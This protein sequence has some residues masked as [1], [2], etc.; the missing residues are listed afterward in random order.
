[1]R[2][3]VHERWSITAWLLLSLASPAA[4]GSAS[5]AY[6]VKDINPAPV[7]RS[8]AAPRGFVV[9]D[10]IA[11]FTA[12]DGWHGRELWRS[13]GTFAGTRMVAD[14]NPG[15]GS[16]SPGDL[17]VIG[18][19]L[20]FRAWDGRRGCGLWRSDG[21][22][23]GTEELAVLHAAID[24]CGRDGMPTD[25]TALGPLVLFTASTPETGAELWRS[26][27][28]IAGTSIVADIAAGPD[29]SEPRALTALAGALY[30]IADDSQHGHELWRSDGS[31]AGT[32]LVRDINRGQ[33]SSVPSGRDHARL[34][35][36]NGVLLFAA[37]D[38]A[39]GTELWRSDG[40]ADGTTL[41][42]D[43][44]PG[45]GLDG[46]RLGDTTSPIA[47]FGSGAVLFFSADRREQPP[48]LIVWRSDGTTPGT[49]AIGAIPFGEGWTAPGNL[50]AVGDIAYFSYGTAAA[51]ALWKVDGDG[52]ERLVDLTGAALQTGAFTAAGDRLLFLAPTEGAGCG[53]WRSDG[54][55]AGSA[56]VRDHAA[57][58]GQCPFDAATSA[59]G[60]YL[61][62]RGAEALLAATDTVRGTELFAS[63]GTTAGTH[64]VR[65]INDA[66]AR[67]Q[68]TFIDLADAIALDDALLFNATVDPSVTRLWRSDGTTDGTEELA[69]VGMDAG[70]V[71]GDRVVFSG[72]DHQG[73]A[74][75]T[76][77][78]TVA[79]T[80]RV[81][82]LPASGEGVA[83]PAGFFL[84]LDF[85]GDGSQ[86]LVSDG[87]A[88]G[89]I[90]LLTFPTRHITRLAGYGA[91]V[92]IAVRDA[93][94]LELW[95]SDGT[96]VGTRY[97]G[98]LPLRRSFVRDMLEVDGTLYFTLANAGQ[99]PELWRSDG[100]R[101]GTTRVVDLGPRGRSLALDWLAA[102][103]GALFFAAADAT[104][105]M[106]LWRS[107]G[108]D[109]GTGRVIDIRPGPAGGL[110]DGG[111]SVLGPPAEVGEALL[112]FA[113]DGTHGPELWRSDG[114]ASGSALVREIDPRQ[115][116][117]TG[118]FN[119]RLTAVGERILFAPLDATAGVEPWVSDGTRAGTRRLADIAP[120]A[121]SGLR[122]F[123]PF[124]ATRTHVFV[125]ADDGLHGSELWAIPRAAVE[126]G[127]DCVGDCDGDAR[128]TVD[129]L[130]RGV[131]IA[132]GGAAADTC[133][134]FDRNADGAVSIAEL[135]AA[136]AAALGAC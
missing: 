122:P 58:P 127:A 11:Y 84:S 5:P 18:E 119:G 113:D 27:G 53:L 98:T 30:F 83:T 1:M 102:G 86:L 31:E 79:G 62:A 64:L 120:G 49:T 125:G 54:T 93:E 81:L 37:T 24:A 9:L 55:I 90:P 32:R 4:A 61:V 16:S 12:D 77:D 92:A 34:A 59:P 26:D 13:D 65:D 135:V 126:G 7:E 28:T 99:G 123:S 105:G 104:A 114:S 17:T 21:T 111:G 23:A 60:T 50:T 68:G 70:G 35:S 128:V 88:T 110:L 95:T 20:W 19:A 3:T 108:T 33:A 91:G 85:G 8:D 117:V 131:G 57:T 96:P 87:T 2:E 69:A 107:D 29:G 41:L 15:E 44:A 97:L 101:S 109:R 52:L 76:S 133:V 124:A 100:T 40:T 106:E 73:P 132:L 118:D 25:F 6:L 51:S 63:D 38:G 36:A 42:V 80:T 82:S 115:R 43:T 136:V 47:A 14:L 22:E 134:S 39:H 103:P 45:I 48:H 67:T 94:M 121:R 10:D 129:E 116:V 72:Y 74:L 46:L 112:F 130:V 75:W 56:L 78:G 89:T 66:S 71:V